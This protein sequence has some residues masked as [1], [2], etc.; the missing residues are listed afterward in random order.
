[1]NK[2][3][4]DF[5]QCVEAIIFGHIH[6]NY[7]EI[8]DIKPIDDIELQVIAKK[9]LSAARKQIANEIDAD[10]MVKQFNKQFEGQHIWEYGL[11]TKAYR[12][13]INDTLKSIKGEACYLLTALLSPK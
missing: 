1:M 11:E 5:E 10:V 7:K 4:T 2:Q 6:L 13:G 12:T 9:L 3:L 8:E